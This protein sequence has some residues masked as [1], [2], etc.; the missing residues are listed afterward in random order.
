MKYEWN[1]NKNMANTERHG[2]DF[3]TSTNL[4][5]DENHIV[6]DAPH[7][8]EDRHIIIGTINNMAWTGVF[9]VRGEKIRIISVRRSRKKETALYEKE[10]TR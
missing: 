4:W 2:I 3:E 1:V 7:P 6:I 5:L 9:T 10:K 8:V